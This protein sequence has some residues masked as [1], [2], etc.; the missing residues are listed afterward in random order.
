MARDTV[1]RISRGIGP[2]SKKQLEAA[3]DEEAVKEGQLVEPSWCK[4]C[5]A[6]VYEP[7]VVCQLRKY[8]KEQ[9]LKGEK[10]GC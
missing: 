10:D 2:F 3:N 5:G 1:S 8:Q 4:A 9:K 7:C 6:T